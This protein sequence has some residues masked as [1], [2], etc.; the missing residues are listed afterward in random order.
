M[1]D[2]LSPSWDLLDVILKSLVRLSQKWVDIPGF[3]ASLE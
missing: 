1:I 3:L 2:D